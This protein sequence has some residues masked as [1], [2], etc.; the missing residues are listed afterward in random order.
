MLRMARR[1]RPPKKSG[2]ITIKSRETQVFVGFLFVALGVSLFIN[3]SLSGTIP[4]FILRNFGQ[5]TYILGVI[6]VCIGLRMI[7][8]KIFLTADRFLTGLFLLLLTMLPL[9]NFWIEPEFGQV[10]ALQGEG[11][12]G[13]GM[14][15]HELLYNLV[16]RAAEFGLLT[17][18]LVLSISILSGI[19]LAQFGD[20]L[21]TVFTFFFR[22]LFGTVTYIGEKIPK[23]EIISH[24]KALNGGLTK[25][26]EKE[27]DL[28]NSFNPKI[29]EMDVEE[30]DL[31]EIGMETAAASSGVAARTDAPKISISYGPDLQGKGKES[32]EELAEDEGLSDLE[33]DFKHRYE[34]R[35]QNWTFAPLDLLD[36]P[37]PD[38]F[39]EEDI[40]DKSKLIEQTLATFKIQARVA[41]IFVGPAIIQYALNLAP[42][43]KV[44]KLVGLAK[45]V[46]LALAASSESI[47]IASIG[48]TSL[49]GI[50]VPRKQGHIVRLREVL[51]SQE[52][53]R[54][55]R[56]LP[57]AIGKDIRGDIVVEDLQ[58]MPHILVAGAT[59]TGKSVTINDLIVGFIMK[60]TPDEMKLILVDP[61]MVEMSLY[62]GLPYL[63]TPVITDMDKVV[64]VLEWAIHEMTQRYKL[65]KEKSVRNLDE[66][67]ESSPFKLPYIIMAID[68]MADLILTKKAEV[69]QKIVRL[70]QLARATGI[71]LILATQRPSVAVITG[72]IKANIPARIALGVTSSIDSRVILDNVGAES[73][74]GKG[75]MLVKSPDATKIRRVQAA[76]VSTKE[77][78]RIT[79]YIRQKAK[80]IMPDENWYMTE[81]Q[82][83]DTQVQVGQ[84][85]FTA[86]D[87]TD[88]PL[89]KQSVS[90]VIQQ[91][92]ASASSL[93]RYLKIGFNRAARLIDQMAVMGI[94]AEGSGSKPR[95]VLVGSLE[96]VFGEKG[97]KD[98]FG[99]ED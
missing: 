85:G 12:G 88:D 11:G 70:A 38:P 24:E 96:E 44:S 67:N 92:K 84:G 7:G 47:R 77:I 20:I 80:N 50:E 49:V 93:Q 27:L 82:E 4:Q 43:T 1:G 56:R 13:I 29:K 87:S 55:V 26:E 97:E 30:M 86:T 98:V 45:D 31:P 37:I 5:T 9:L 42:G 79:D 41:K 81:I 14:F 3:N 34:N 61:K 23:P 17:A 25:E 66:F 89:F 74:I 91:G 46:S 53:S 69:E 65:F 73:L 99:G 51:E 32:E 6:S 95:D 22:T 64:G 15:I 71:H 58:Q 16:G 75:D 78:Q 40:Y 60:F 28:E 21:N 33:K 59:G 94:V 35:F 36:K 72:L 83:M 68:E 63:L 90:L 76:Y 18:F 48:G 10:R 57:L 2:E 19:S 62:N 52:M 54:D 8:V 39:K